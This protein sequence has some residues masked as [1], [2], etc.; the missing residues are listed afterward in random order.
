MSDHSV[1]PT[2][3]RVA[4]LPWPE[5][6][7]CYL[8]LSGKIG[9]RQQYGDKWYAG[10]E[11]H[12][13]KF[14]DDPRTTPA[15]T[16]TYV[17]GGIA[18]EWDGDS[19]P[20]QLWFKSHEGYKEGYDEAREHWLWPWAFGAGHWSQRAVDEAGLVRAFNL[21]DWHRIFGELKTW[22]R[23]RLPDKDDCDSGIAET[24]PESPS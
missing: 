8:V 3:A 2:M 19:G 10:H 16:F 17:E 6:D 9:K 12:V 7:G 4:V 23:A 15:I 13:W 1:E 21:G 11:E 18:A 22:V 14:H 24:Q 5:M 20:I